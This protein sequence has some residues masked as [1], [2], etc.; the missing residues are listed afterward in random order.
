LL[1]EPFTGLDVPAMEDLT[2][3]LHALREQGQS[4]ILVTHEVERAA[5]LADSAL[6]VLGGR[7]VQEIRGASLNPETLSAAYR[8]ALERP[9]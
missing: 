5:T 3:R 6:L 9:A 2:R 1:D 7:I 4:W 8:S